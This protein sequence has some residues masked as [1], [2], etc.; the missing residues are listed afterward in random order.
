MAEE[1]DL[2]S[3]RA[4]DAPHP[5]AAKRRKLGHARQLVDLTGDQS[6]PGKPT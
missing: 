4:A 5:A 2:T 1:I 6:D 3:P